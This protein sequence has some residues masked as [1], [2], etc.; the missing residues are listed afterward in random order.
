M[1]IKT[2]FLGK[3]EGLK[4]AVYKLKTVCSLYMQ[5]TWSVNIKYIRLDMYLRWETLTKPDREPLFGH[6]NT[7]DRGLPVGLS[8]K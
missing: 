2:N 8:P 6:G 5:Y 4:E 1:Q 3:I 7:F